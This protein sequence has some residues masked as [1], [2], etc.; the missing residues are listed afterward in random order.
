MPTHRKT[1]TIVQYNAHAS[2]DTVLVEFLRRMEETEDRPMV[3]AIQEPWR[4]QSRNTTTATPSYYLAHAD[5]PD[6]R[7]CFYINKEI[8][9]SDWEIQV[10]SKDLCTLL[11]RLQDRTVQIHNLYNPQP[12]GHTAEL[13]GLFTPGHEHMLVGDFNLHHPLWGGE[14]VVAVEDEAAELVRVTRAAGLQLT[15]E[16]GIETWRRNHQRTTIDLAFTSRW[17]T[18]RVL[19]CQI[20]DSW[21]TDSDHWPVLTEFDIQPPEAMEPPGRP[22]W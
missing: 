11:L 9:L 15:T 17:L 4:P 8:A 12:R 6:V 3:I 10:H 7:T 2:R 20:K 22:L 21:H 18:E 1:I 5:I 16:R 13:P 19:Q 14:R